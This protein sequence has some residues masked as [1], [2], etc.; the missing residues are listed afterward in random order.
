MPRLGEEEQVI[1]N[2]PEMLPVW[3]RRVSAQAGDTL[4]FVLAPTRRTRHPGLPP[5][6]ISRVLNRSQCVLGRW[7]P[8]RL[9]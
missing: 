2:R 9:F 6:R 5:Y 4:L 1:E 7:H 8:W 3:E